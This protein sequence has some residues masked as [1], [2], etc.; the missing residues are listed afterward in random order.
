MVQK[1]SAAGHPMAL[2]FR[3]DQLRCG[4]NGAVMDVSGGIELCRQAV[5]LGVKEAHYTLGQMY[6]PGG[7]LRLDFI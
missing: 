2:C 7:H 1:K 5:E 3:G 6:G 4:V